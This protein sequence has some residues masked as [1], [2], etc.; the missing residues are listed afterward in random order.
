M[1]G[2]KDIAAPL[3]EEKKGLENDRRERAHPLR[4]TIIGSVTQRLERYGP[5]ENVVI[6][7]HAF[8]KHRHHEATKA[9]THDN[10]LGA[11]VFRLAGETLSGIVCEK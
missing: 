6:D 9:S 7:T 10:H 11:T 2:V 8:Q 1:P 3:T 4:E 5:L